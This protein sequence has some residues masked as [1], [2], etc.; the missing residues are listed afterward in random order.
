MAAGGL[1][2]LKTCFGLR[3]KSMVCCLYLWDRRKKSR[4]GEVPHL[5]L[6]SVGDGVNDVAMNK[7]VHVKVGICGRVPG[8]VGIGAD[9]WEVM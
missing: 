9:A 6:L 1:S 2:L 3:C 7:E 4:L 5:L 8:S